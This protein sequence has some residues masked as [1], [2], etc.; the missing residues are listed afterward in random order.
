MMSH[1]FFCATFTTSPGIFF[2]LIGQRF[3]WRYNHDTPCQRRLASPLQK[4]IQ[5]YYKRNAFIAGA[6]AGVSRSL[7]LRV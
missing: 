3:C 4:K 1:G 2:G 6:G 7:R 5:Q